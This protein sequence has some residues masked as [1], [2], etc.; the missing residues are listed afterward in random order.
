MSSSIKDLGKVTNTW[1]IS[2][3]N[4]S[5]N[6]IYCDRLPKIEKYLYKSRVFR[7][8]GLSHELVL[9]IALLEIIGGVLLIVGVLTRITTAILIIGIIGATL[10]W[11]SPGFAG[12]PLIKQS[13]ISTSLLLS[14]NICKS[15]T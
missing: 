13:A 5:R 12:G 15:N 1:N 9:S 14:C 4:S 10:V 6:S 7:G 3:T 11:L 8:L 2:N